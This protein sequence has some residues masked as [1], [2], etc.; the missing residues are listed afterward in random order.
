[1]S[2]LEIRGSIKIEIVTKL[3]KLGI[4]KSTLFPDVEGLCGHIN[5][6]FT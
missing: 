3:D 4:N 2:E 5:S 1:M 6:L